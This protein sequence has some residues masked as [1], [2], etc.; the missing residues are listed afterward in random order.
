MVQILIRLLCAIAAGYL[1]WSGIAEK[2]AQDLVSI[3]SSFASVSGTLFG[4]LLAALSILTALSDRLLV[5]NMIKTGHYKK[6][7]HELYMAASF[8][9]AVV[10]ISL[11]ALFVPNESL[12]WLVIIAASLMVTATLVFASAFKKFYTV[13][14]LLK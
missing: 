7:L 6:L 8:Y 10:I 13:I 1:A 9:L 4:F 3:A 2:S 14:S 12:P 11:A 5:A